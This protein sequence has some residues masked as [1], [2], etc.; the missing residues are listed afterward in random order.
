MEILERNELRLIGITA[1]NA[2]WL[3]SHWNHPKVGE[4]LWDRQPV[5][6][7]TVQE[8]IAAS[9]ANFAEH[10]WGLW[11]IQQD[12]RPV[13]VCGLAFVTSDE[14]EPVY[15]LEPDFWGKGIATSASQM[16]LQHVFE[17]TKLT[18]LDAGFDEGN[19]HSTA[20]LERLGFRPFETRETP[21]GKA[22]YWRIQKLTSG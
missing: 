16:V 18:Y 4:F 22:H 12:G 7:E 2:T 6:I 19:H 21:V 17:N 10:G 11:L 8:V 14:P 20:V 9:E 3:L 5:P 1:T 13:G 15:S